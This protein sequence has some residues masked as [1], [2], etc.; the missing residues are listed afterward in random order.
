MD[1]GDV[2]AWWRGL[3]SELVNRRRP[4]FPPEWPRS[5]RRGQVR[6]DDLCR[7]EASRRRGPLRRTSGRAAGVP[8]DHRTPEKSPSR[9][10]SEVAMLP[11]TADPSTEVFTL[12]RTSMVGGTRPA[13]PLPWAGRP[14]GVG[15]GWFH[16]DPGRREDRDL[17]GVCA[18]TRN[19]M[20][21]GS[22]RLSEERGL[23]EQVVSSG[24]PGT[25]IAGGCFQLDTLSTVH[26]SPVRRGP[27]E[28]RKRKVSVWRRFEH[29]SPPSPGGLQ[30]HRGIWWPQVRAPRSSAHG[31]SRGAPRAPV[32]SAARIVDLSQRAEDPWF[33]KE[34]RILDYATTSAFQ[35][36]EMPSRT[37]RRSAYPADASTAGV[38][39]GNVHQN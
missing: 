14:A 25:G 23:L 31:R 28:P 24:R 3:G 21:T 33:P 39:F 18:E 20:R 35:K 8:T 29:G 15:A 9:Q 6:P 16:A 13:A 17:G 7:S 36:R 27:R 19:E 11:E 34:Q 32:P 30:R 2:G 38:G 22:R 5:A 26:R 10:A 4:R 37:R 12:R 1:G